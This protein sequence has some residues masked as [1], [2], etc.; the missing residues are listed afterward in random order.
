MYRIISRKP[1]TSKERRRMKR[2]GIKKRKWKN[3]EGRK[4]KERGMSKRK[5]EE[6]WGQNKCY[7]SQFF[8]CP[9][10]LKV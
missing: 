4:K 1:R 10:V 6:E 2:D 3:G 8:F 9:K 7:T 5:R